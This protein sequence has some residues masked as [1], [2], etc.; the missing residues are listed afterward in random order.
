MDP[1]VRKL[2]PLFEVGAGTIIVVVAM[3]V[4]PRS[5]TWLYLGFATL[6]LVPLVHVVLTG[7][8]AEALMRELARVTA[9]DLDDLDKRIDKLADTVQQ[10][11]KPEGAPLALA[12]PSSTLGGVLG[13]LLD[14]ADK[15]ASAA[16]VPGAK[17][18][19]PAKLPGGGDGQR[20]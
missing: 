17:T 15:L 20:G 6:A 12:P 5:D 2:L 18:P 1:L 7:M 11:K 4:E 9:H 3:I 13:R 16:P 19:S 14:L 10:L 8:H